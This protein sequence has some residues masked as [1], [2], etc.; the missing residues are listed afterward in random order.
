MEKQQPVDLPTLSPSSGDWEYFWHQLP[1]ALP[2]FLSFVISLF[3]IWICLQ[4]YFSRE[5]RN[6]YLSYSVLFL[7]VGFLS[8]IL[9]L[10]STIQSVEDLSA[11]HN[12]IYAFVLLQSPMYFVVYYYIN[13]KKNKVLL[14]FS[15]ISWFTVFWGIVDIFS[16]NAF[17]GEWNEYPFGK[18]PIGG[19]SL[20]VWGAFPIVLYLISI[21]HTKAKISPI[22]KKKI[23]K[24]LFY[25]FHLM[26][27]LL[28]SNFPSLVGYSV[29]PLGMF[30]FIPIL[31]MTYSLFKDDYLNFNQLFIDK[32]LG[33][34]GIIFLVVGVLVSLFIYYSGFL[35]PEEGRVIYTY[36]SLIPLVSMLLV[37]GLSAYIAGMNPTDKLSLYASLLLLVT[38]FLQI[39]GLI[40]SIQDNLI[41]SY[42]MEQMLYFVFILIPAINTRFLFMV[43]G[44]KNN[45]KVR[46]MDIACVILAFFT[47]SA[48]LFDGYYFYE[49]G[50]IPKSGPVLKIFILVAVISLIFVYSEWRKIPDPQK[51]KFQKW[52]FASI[53]FSN[54]LILLNIPSVSGLE[55]YPLGNLQFLPILFIGYTLLRLGKKD[56]YGEA[57]KISNRY[58]IFILLISIVIMSLYSM[59]LPKHSNPEEIQTFLILLWVLFYLVNYITSFVVI[60]PVASL[61]DN[62]YQ[63]LLDSIEISESTKKRKEDSH[64]ELQQLNSLLRKINDMTEIKVLVYE[65]SQFFREM[66]SIQDTWLL[67]VDEENKILYTIDYNKKD[68]QALDEKSHHWIMNF[69]YNLRDTTGSFYRVYNRKKFAYYSKRILD[70]IQNPIDREIIQYLGIESAIHFPLFVN[71]QCIGIFCTTVKESHSFQKNNL[72]RFEAFL[73][74]IAGGIHRTNLLISAREARKESEQIAKNIRDIVSLNRSIIENNDIN[75]IMD[76]VLQ[77]LED[78]F[79]FNPYYML[80]IVS[81]DGVNLQYYSGNIETYFDDDILKVIKGS[82]I[83]L[84]DENNFHTQVYRRKRVIYI[85][86]VEK[87]LGEGLEGM[88]IQALGLRNI[89]GIPLVNQ[90]RVIGILNI[91]ERSNKKWNI[92]YQVKMDLEKIGNQ[93]S[94]AIEKSIKHD[95]VLKAKQKQDRYVDSL[96]VLNRVSSDFNQDLDLKNVLDKL[97]G[98]LKKQF[99]IKQYG[100]ALVDDNGLTAHFEY[101]NLYNLMSDPKKELL[102][103]WKIDLTEATGGHALCSRKKRDL[104]FPVL[105]WNKVSSSEIPVIRELRIKS[106]LIIPLIIKDKVIGFIDLY[107]KDRLN[108]KKDDRSFL[109]EF[110]NMIATAVWNSILVRNLQTALDDLQSSQDQLIQ[111]EKMAAL[112]QLISGV[113]HEIN[114]PLGAIK[115]SIGN[116]EI[117]LKESL[118]LLPEVL[119]TGSEDDWSLIEKF[120][121]KSLLTN[122]ILSTR[123]QRSIRKELVRSMED[124]GVSR[125]EETSELFLDIGIYEY[126]PKFK[127]LWNNPN[128]EKYQKLIYYLSGFRLKS[129]VVEESVN[130][131]SKIV[132]ALKNYAHFD[133][134]DTLQSSDIVEGIETVLT[135]YHNSIKK[136]IELERNFS[137]SP[138]IMCYPDELNQIWTNLLHNSIQA[139]NGEGR[140]SI[141]TS[142]EEDSGI[143]EVLFEDNGPGVPEPIREKI[144]SPF[145]TTKGRG[146]GSGLGLHIV[147]KIINKHKGRIHLDS[148]PGRT[149]FTIQLPYDPEKLSLL[150]ENTNGSN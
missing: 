144:F 108:L 33:F 128:R 12:Y 59:T 17:T 87:I 8:L 143:L 89:M 103:N 44:V 71:D 18:Y 122:Q 77:Y 97:E 60:R 99:S 138:N 120:L 34:Y 121:D 27:L 113:A 36:Y 114:T 47:Q 119:K 30:M 72:E 115:A 26:V 106:L 63:D 79:D 90:D 112:G 123:E 76:R 135:I 28:V 139:M 137:K 68:L 129:L 37:F 45:I 127:P 43:F 126:D 105:N 148:S 107:D 149:I 14:Y 10:R 32:K 98:F 15:Y 56:S 83:S 101:T 136:G 35:K 96:S 134:T 65:V 102:N 24:P 131:A 88:V 70:K 81:N 50:K 51:T 146:E 80:Y 42:R 66:F 95:Y 61:L 109:L 69:R 1:Y 92:D 104:F 125:P 2:G 5:K 118:E 48:Y 39:I 91:A 75:E 130:R 55:I 54:F 141:S 20:Q 57:V 117:S 74:L 147:K 78:R 133:H 4:A 7:S 13:I 84:V 23:N 6:E 40:R 16:G 150:E 49:F 64:R 31:V 116:I 142:F 53:T 21:F 132:D 52:T 41:V 94:S 73:S 11:L 111:S 86:N 145:F 9:G 19:L 58:S 46:I 25:S 62:N 22:D 3:L 110:S 124:D 100:L 85:R 93:I 140:I 82:Y 29:Y 67:M 38:G